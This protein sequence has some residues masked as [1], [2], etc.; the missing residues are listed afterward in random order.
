LTDP[1]APVSTVTVRRGFTLIELL[2][3]IAIIA[4]LIA[5]LLPAVQAAREAARR[6]QC[7]NN[8]KQLALAVMNYESVNN[9]FPPGAIG[10]DPVTGNYPT[11]TQLGG[12]DRQPF[13][14]AILRFIEQG[15]LF[16]AYNM[17]F[18]FERIEN[19]TVRGTV[20][21][22]YN[23]P[24]DTAQVFFK[25]T[26]DYDVKG[27]Y[28][29]N[30]GQVNFLNQGLRAPFFLLYGAAFADITDGTSNTL[31]MLEVRQTPSPNTTVLDRRGRVWNDD[32]ACYQVSTTLTP[33]SSAPDFSA[34]Q[35]NPVPNTPCINGGV[36]G[37]DN[38]QFYMAA[39]SLHPGGVNASFCDGSVRFIKNSINLA[40]WKALSSEA[41]GEV[42][43]ADSY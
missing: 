42:V 31:M 22:V 34:C 17:N 8:L 13:L 36:S 41:G 3:V 43:S 19:Q 30:W 16:D 25:T 39:R 38:S 37:P 21:T 32:S 23:C 6:A 28:G 7:V 1:E 14:V 27:S 24:S 18:Q 5:L 12:F 40:T 15:T 9:R 11:S 35:N 20:I 10:R 33:N 29:V 2:V 26:T 4:V